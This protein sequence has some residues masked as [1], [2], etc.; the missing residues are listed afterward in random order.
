MIACGPF[1]AGCSSLLR[2]EACQHC[3]RA[4]A[5]FDT[6]RFF[7]ALEQCVMRGVSHCENGVVLRARPVRQRLRP[8]DVQRVAAVCARRYP[9][10]I[11]VFHLR[12]RACCLM[13]H[14]AAP[15]LVE[16][17]D[18]ATHMMAPPALAY[19]VLGWGRGV[20]SMDVSRV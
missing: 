5:A 17:T 10:G 14:G 1:C 16:L 8:K 7:A 15:A 9:M 19:V 2:V 4:Q 18:A 20:A 12:E 13:K 3:V 6:D 11:L